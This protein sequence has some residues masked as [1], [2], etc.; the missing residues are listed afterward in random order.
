MST[1]PIYV[2]TAYDHRDQLSVWAFSSIPE[3]EEFMQT[4]KELL[5]RDIEF[6]LCY[7]K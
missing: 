2:I 1:E 6:N 3:A 5:W 4:L 7:V